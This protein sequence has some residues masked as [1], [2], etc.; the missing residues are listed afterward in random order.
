MDKVIIGFDIRN[1]LSAIGD[2]IPQKNHPLNLVHAGR[3]VSSGDFI[4]Q[5]DKPKIAVIQIQCAK[6]I[7]CN[8]CYELMSSRSSLWG[9]RPGDTDW[10]VACA[11]VLTGTGNIH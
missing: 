10:G 6:K 8:I 9:H 4:W 1:I 7:R 3:S 5:A 11:C 2:A